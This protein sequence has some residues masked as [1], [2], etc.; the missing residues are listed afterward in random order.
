MA[1]MVSRIELRPGGNGDWK[2][3]TAGK[4]ADAGFSVV[5]SGH[6]W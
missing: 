1:T 6:T 5:E 2:T 3:M 4:L